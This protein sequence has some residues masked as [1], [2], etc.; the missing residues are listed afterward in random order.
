M[1]KNYLF[2]KTLNPQN[3]A[4]KN[5]DPEKFVSL[6]NCGPEKKNW[7]LKKFGSLKY[8]GPKR[9]WVLKHLGTKKIG[10]YKIWVLK[11]LVPKNFG[12]EKIWVQN[13]F[14]TQKFW[15]TKNFG[16]KTFELGWVR[17]ASSRFG[18]LSRLGWSCWLSWL[19]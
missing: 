6:K 11:I 2:Q 1:P 18:Q 5:L 3:L 7:V 17:L 14:R 19:G 4:K 9:I 10:P 12:P 8:W 15:T 13:K 16:P